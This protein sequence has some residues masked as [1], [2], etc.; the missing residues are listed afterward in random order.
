MKKFVKNW[1]AME[2]LQWMFPVWW[3]WIAIC[4]TA[5]CIPIL[6]YPL[7]FILTA[8]GKALLSPFPRIAEW[9]V[10]HYSVYNDDMWLIA[11]ADC[12][13]IL[14]L[15]CIFSTIIDIILA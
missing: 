6:G 2:M 8:G 5:I 7:Q 12:G 14:F 4:L 13:R 9:A 3:I 1:I 11:C 10:R 15:S